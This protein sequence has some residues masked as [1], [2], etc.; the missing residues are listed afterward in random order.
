MFVSGL[1]AL[2]TLSST[3]CEWDNVIV[4][5]SVQYCLSMPPGNGLAVSMTAPQWLYIGHTDVAWQH[6]E[7]V[8]DNGVSVDAARCHWSHHTWQWSYTADIIWGGQSVPTISSLCWYHFR[9]ECLEVFSP[10]NHQWHC[11]LHSLPWIHQPQTQSQSVLCNL[12]IGTTTL[13]QVCQCWQPQILHKSCRDKWGQTLPC[14]HRSHSQ[15]R[16]KFW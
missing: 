3:H 16:V 13:G 4:L 5:L 1:K 6:T 7:G 2:I 15:H 8:V 10:H 11:H 14:S 9:N 12:H